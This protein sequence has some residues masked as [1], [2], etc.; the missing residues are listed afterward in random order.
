MSEQIKTEPSTNTAAIVPFGDRGMEPT[1][2]DGLKRMA[3]MIAMSPFAPAGFKD[4]PSICVA[5]DYGATIGLRPMQALQCIAVINGKP[6]LYG[7]GL[8]GVV[9]GSGLCDW[10]KE[11]VEGAGQ[12]MVGWCETQRKGEPCTVKRTFSVQDAVS[13][14]LWGKAGPWKNYASR[15]LMLRARGFCLRDAY[16]DV[17][18]GFISAEESGDIQ[19]ERASTMDARI[20][21]TTHEVVDESVPT[22][23][24]IQDLPPAVAESGAARP[25]P[26]EGD[27][28]SDI[29]AAMTRSRKL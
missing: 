27:L 23:I 6:C 28:L 15:M 21:D 14:G 29:D 18:K 25:A 24:I 12:G 4:V 11:G 10:I 2:M 9:R 7:D 5:I 8:I 13:A 3:N 20:V 22:E 16:A 1:D 26:V 17:L 19:G